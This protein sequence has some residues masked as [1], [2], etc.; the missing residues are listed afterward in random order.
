MEPV[1]TH[2]GDFRPLRRGASLI[3]NRFSTNKGLWEALEATVPPL[4]KD[5]ERERCFSYDDRERVKDWVSRLRRMARSAAGS[6]P[7]YPRWTIQLYCVRS[8]WCLTCLHSKTII[9]SRLTYLLSA[10]AATAHKILLSLLVVQTTRALVIYSVDSVPSVFSKICS[11]NSDYVVCREKLFLCF[12][13]THQACN[14]PLR[15][16]DSLLST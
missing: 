1:T 14:A 8:T 3:R 11:Y 2:P 15:T 12:L 6:S 5:D 13:S 16:T 4:L 10:S 9:N 7:C